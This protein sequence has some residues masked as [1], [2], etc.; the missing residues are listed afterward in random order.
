[1]SHIVHP[2]VLSESSNHAFLLYHHHPA[3]LQLPVSSFERGKIA[4]SLDDL[5]DDLV[6]VADILTVTRDGGICSKKTHHWEDRHK[7]ER[8]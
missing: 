6:L 1:M 5:L 8:L 2:P 7:Q 4:V 3:T